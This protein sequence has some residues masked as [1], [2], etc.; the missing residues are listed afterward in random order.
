MKVFCIVALVFCLFQS[1]H[2]YASPLKQL[3]ACPPLPPHT[4]TDIRDLHPND[5]SVV[6][7]LGD[8]I[9]AGFGLMG[10]KAE[11]IFDEFRGK[12]WSIG[13]DPEAVTLANFFRMFNSNLYGASTSVHLVELPYTDY[14]ATDRCNGAQSNAGVDNLLYQLDHI[15]EVL[16]S[17]PNISIEKDWKLVT[18]LIGANDACPLCWEFD[19][20]TVQQAADSFESYMSQVILEF[21]Q[22]IPRTFFNVLPL[23]NISQVYYLSLNTSYCD[24]VHIS[25]P[26]ECTCA[27]DSDESNRIYLDSVVQAYASRLAKLE[28]EWKAKNLSD[29]IVQIQP[30]SQNLVI[31]N[32]NYLSTLDCFH[33]SLLAH[34][35]LAIATW[36]SLLTPV[37][38]KP[39]HLK[40]N[41]PLICPT[42]DTLL[43][44]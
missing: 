14:Y 8:S 24:D 39:Q 29:F 27:F 36:N 12:S 10:L 31:P 26:V 15:V 44:T 18:V 42:A 19:R 4:P 43:Y 17:N 41:Q 5:I 33:P 30:F 3:A 20:P 13:G 28:K 21:S 9:T 32:I 22:K 16:K 7:A 34:Q 25:L 1:V 6:M 38:K 11:D 35:Q 40:P 23:F 2:G 37:G